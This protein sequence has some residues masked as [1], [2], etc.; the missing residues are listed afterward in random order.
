M[1]FLSKPRDQ[2]KAAPDAAAPQK[3]SRKE[4]REEEISAYFRNVTGERRTAAQDQLEQVVDT[5]MHVH[6]TIEDVAEPVEQE[7]LPAH[8][9]APVELPDKPFLGFGSRG[10]PQEKQDLQ[11]TSKSY[12]TWSESIAPPKRPSLDEGRFL[13]PDPPQVLKERTSAQRLMQNDPA[14]EQPRRRV[15]ENAPYLESA[16]G[17]TI[18]APR[19]KAR[20]AD[21][22]RIH[23]DDQQRWASDSYHTSDILKL[24]DTFHEH[25][26]SPSLPR[27][28]HCSNPSLDQENINPITST[29][30]SKLL[31]NA[32]EAVARPQ[33]H[34]QS[35]STR[36]SSGLR[37]H[38]R[39]QPHPGVLIME[40]TRQYFDDTLH[41]DR[42]QPQPEH[43]PVEHMTQ[44]GF[45]RTGESHVSQHGR[46][47]RSAS[48]T[49][50][51][52]RILGRSNPP[53][54]R[55]LAQQRHQSNEMLDNALPCP[56]PT[57]PNGN[58]YANSRQAEDLVR[59]LAADRVPDLYGQSHMNQEEHIDQHESY[60][61]NR[62]FS[63]VDA[64]QEQYSGVQEN[65]QGLFLTEPH[66]MQMEALDHEYR[67]D[68]PF[69][70]PWME[71]EQYH[72]EIPP[73]EPL[74]ES[75][76]ADN[77]AGFW[78]PNVLY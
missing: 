66:S 11:S 65:P 4:L 39:A 68:I 54:A 71:P 70:E 29:P 74:M 77:M 47:L 42:G 21:E 28:S 3:K 15:S 62:T 53:H 64:G 7:N 69:V 18:S 26:R 43:P 73:V 6:P 51:N 38:D 67:T 61:Q 5:P 27:R 32:W 1:K 12:Y 10:G 44:R 13:Q 24:R 48:A 57:I 34:H 59:Q 56:R 31:R 58:V 75:E 78:K 8:A 14:S 52:D 40:P 9:R 50:T 41:Y 37:R 17:S 30:T 72:T 63:S 55:R 33:Q 36:R 45:S 46:S 76:P 16:L 25:Q 60:D 20:A 35:S 2:G 22:P 49:N 23:E 19:R